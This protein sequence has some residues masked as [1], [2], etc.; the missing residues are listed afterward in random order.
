MAKFDI[1]YNLMIKHEGGYV[2]N[3]HD[4][5]GETYKGIARNFH[6]NLPLWKIIDDI[7]KIHGVK[8]INTKLSKMNNV[9]KQVKDFYNNKFW[10]PIRLNSLT[11]QDL[12]NELFDMAVNAG[13]GIVKLYMMKITKTTNIK[14]AIERFNN[15][16]HL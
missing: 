1:A 8:N 15:K 11:N 9:Q 7:K 2:N 10:I 12:A 13:I 3:P 16:D 14:D 6:N 4:R 5:G